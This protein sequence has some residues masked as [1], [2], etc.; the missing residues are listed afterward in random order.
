MYV[1]KNGN[2]VSD[3]VM[4]VEN[5]RRKNKLIESFNLSTIYLHNIIMESIEKLL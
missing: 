3:L 5:R 2:S 4:Y 1:D